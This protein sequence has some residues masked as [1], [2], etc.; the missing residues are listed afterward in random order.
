MKAFCLFV[1]SSLSAQAAATCRI[2]LPCANASASPQ[3]IG[4]A[5]DLHLERRLGPYSVQSR[6]DPG[7][8]HPFSE[9][10]YG[11][12]EDCDRSELPGTAQRKVPAERICSRKH[13]EPC[14][15]KITARP[16]GLADV[17]VH[18]L[19]TANG[20]DIRPARLKPPSLSW[21]LPS[22][23]H[24]V[25]HGGLSCTDARYISCRPQPC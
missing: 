6:Q 24:E 14:L 16:R 4:E 3:R 23:D 10:R 17:K 5:G 7:R 13:G 1:C 20:E 22:V 21:F 18:F 25:I 8:A 15:E 12:G 9:R 19:F 11:P 2:L